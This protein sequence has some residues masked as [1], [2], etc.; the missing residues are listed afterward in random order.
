MFVS[1]SFDIYLVA[2]LNIFDISTA[3]VAATFAFAFAQCAIETKWNGMEY[4][5]H[6]LMRI[7]QHNSVDF[8]SQCELISHCTLYSTLTTIIR[9]NNFIRRN[10]ITIQ[11]W[12]N[13]CV[14]T[15]QT[16][17]L[18]FVWARTMCTYYRYII[19]MCVCLCVC[20]CID[21]HIISL[22]YLQCLKFCLL[23]KYDSVIQ[24]CECE[25][26]CW[27]C[28]WCECLRACHSIN[29][30]IIIS[31]A[32]AAVATTIQNERSRMKRNNNSSRVCVPFSIE[33]H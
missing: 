7:T 23:S 21:T 3:A 11:W 19:Q 5:A 12:Y 31:A 14:C 8:V 15:P 6:D 28:C 27:C 1:L 30:T 22:A 32:A 16:K 24:K 17:R 33:S 13:S 20:V 18:N 25:C 29:N 9:L 4:V 2:F 10:G 26:R